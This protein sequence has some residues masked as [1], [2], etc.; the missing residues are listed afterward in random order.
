MSQRPQLRAHLDMSHRAAACR[1][2]FRNVSTFIPNRPD[3]AVIAA[4]S[5]S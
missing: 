1:I 4:H 3:T 2:H 5:E